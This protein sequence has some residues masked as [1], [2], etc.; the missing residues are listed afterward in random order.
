MSRLLVFVVQVWCWLR[1]GFRHPW[2]RQIELHRHVGP[3]R[4]TV[5]RVCDGC[6]ASRL[7]RA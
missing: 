5:V 3:W 2:A 4:D 6:G 1:H 7:F